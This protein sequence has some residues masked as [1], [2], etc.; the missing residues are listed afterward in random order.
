VKGL[1]I[2]A[3]FKLTLH[4]K[5]A[6]AC[7]R[8]AGW[9]VRLVGAVL[10]VVFGWIAGLIAGVVRGF[11]GWAGEAWLTLGGVTCSS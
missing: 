10:H 5:P 4:R 6:T 7:R 1:A 2:Q 11:D 9:A 8:V 3:G